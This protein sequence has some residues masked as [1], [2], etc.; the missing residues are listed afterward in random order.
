MKGLFENHLCKPKHAME[1][2]VNN[3]HSIY[4]C[5]VS[6]AMVMEF[7]SI[8]TITRVI[9][10]LS[11]EVKWFRLHNDASLM[12]NA[13]AKINKGSMYCTPLIITKGVSPIDRPK[14]RTLSLELSLS[15]IIIDERRLTDDMKA[16]INGGIIG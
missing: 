15:A 9:M 4:V 8:R 16:N 2:R 7:A 14:H 13:K 11:E 6:E 5:F 10:S 1:Y 3:T 12:N